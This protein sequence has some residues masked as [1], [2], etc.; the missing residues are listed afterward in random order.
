MAALSLGIS[1]NSPS[2]RARG[3]PARILLLPR[4]TPASASDSPEPASSL[5]NT[6]GLG[7]TPGR[8]QDV[9]KGSRFTVEGERCVVS[10]RSLLKRLKVIEEEEEKSILLLPRQTPESG[11]SVRFA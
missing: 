10:S 1:G 4:Q 5:T 6:M 2:P 9:C 7:G 3:D 8:C 11:S